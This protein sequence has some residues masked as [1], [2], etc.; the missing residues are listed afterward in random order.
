MP[1]NFLIISSQEE[2]KNVLNYIKK[3]EQILENS[4]PLGTIGILANN[5]LTQFFKE[6]DS[7]ISEYGSDDLDS[8]E[9]KENFLRAVYYGAVDTL[10]LNEDSFLDSYFVVKVLNFSISGHNIIIE[11]KIDNKEEAVNNISN[12]FKKY[13]LSAFLDSH[14]VIKYISDSDINIDTKQNT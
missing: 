6:K 1:S 4:I 2:V 5:D 12:L 9:N 8:P 10:I 13:N 14:I 11:T 7:D 3:R